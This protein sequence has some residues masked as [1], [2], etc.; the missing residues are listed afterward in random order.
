MPDITIVALMAATTFDA[1]SQRLKWG[2]PLFQLEQQKFPRE[3]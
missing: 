2:K 1:P 3:M